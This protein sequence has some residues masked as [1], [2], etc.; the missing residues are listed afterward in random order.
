MNQS[1]YHDINPDKAHDN[2]EQWQKTK[3]G[4]VLPKKKR[5]EENAE[6]LENK[7]DLI[8]DFTNQD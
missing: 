4:N 7:L 5:W 8:N 1:N 6:E 3:Y 2:Y